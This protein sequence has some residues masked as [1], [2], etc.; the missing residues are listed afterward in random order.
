M[1]NETKIIAYKAFNKDMTC[2]GGGEP[3]QFEV[4][5]EFIHTGQVEVCGSGFHACEYPLDIFNY[6]DPCSSMFALTEM[7]GV[8]SRKEEGDTKLASEKI[9]I[10][11]EVTLTE[12]ILAAVEYTTSRA[13]LEEGATASGDSGAATASGYGGKVKGALSCALF[14]TERNDNYEIINVWAA[15]VGKDGI[16]PDIWYTLKNGKITE[17]NN[18]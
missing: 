11:K 17:V 1:T 2:S 4:G 3:F 15:I 18:E 13:V 9:F 7:S 6:Y 14:L 5:K 8:I 16:L 12:L 10:K